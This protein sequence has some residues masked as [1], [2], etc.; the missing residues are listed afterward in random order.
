[1][2]AT[3]SALQFDRVIALGRVFIDLVGQEGFLRTTANASL[4]GLLFWLVCALAT[5]A[6]SRAAV[7]PYHALA[8]HVERLVDG[9]VDVP[10][11]PR[12]QGAG[13]RRLALAFDVLHQR[14]LASRRSEAGLQARYDSL[15]QE[16]ADERR[17]LMGMLM[18]GRLEPE[19]PSSAL[20]SPASVTAATPD[21]P[22]S[23]APASQPT[24][25]RA[26]HTGGYDRLQ[27]E[28]SDERQLLIGMLMSNQLN[29]EDHAYVLQALT[30]MA[31]DEFEYCEPSS[32]APESASG[33][34]P[35]SGADRRSAG[36]P[37]FPA[38][39]LS[40]TRRSA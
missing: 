36:R 40:L 15:C 16:Q 30:G 12:G 34:T 11:D 37:E 29:P 26:P 2:L 19:R 17:L 18:S 28:P 22:D 9:A 31:P 8:D 14:A 3:L 6:I 33:L 35:P 13:V 21:I 38:D 1:M 27:L 32:A 7:K 4:T 5:R 25:R 39:H 10:L 24:G 20:R 23:T